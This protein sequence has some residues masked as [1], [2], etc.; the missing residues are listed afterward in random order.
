[1]PT[2]PP[3][4]P[5]WLM[6]ETKQSV[7]SC[8]NELKRYSTFG[9]ELLAVYAAVKHF[10]PSIEGREFIVYT[11][12]KPLVRA[13]ENGSQ[14]LTDREIRQLDFVTSFQLQMRHISDCMPTLSA[15]EIAQAQSVDPELEWVKNHTSL[16]LVSEPVQNCA[17][18]IWKDTSMAE[19]RIYIPATL[20]L[21]LF[22][23][24]HGLSHP[25][26]RATKRLFVTR[27]VWPG[28]QRDVAAWTRRC[29]HCQRT[30]I[31]RH[32]RSPPKEIPLPSSRFEHVHLDIVGPLPPCEGFRYLLTAM[33]RFTRW[34]EAWPIRDMT[35]Q[36]VAETFLSNWIA[37]FGV[38]LRITTDRGRQFESQVWL[39][40]SRFLGTHHIPTSAYH[41]QANGLVERFHRQLKAALIARMQAVRVKW[42][43][44]LPLVLLGIRTALKAD[45]GLAP[46]EMVYG[47]TLRLP[48]DFLSPRAPSAPDDPTC[49]TS[50]LKAAMRKLRPTP[51]RRN[52]TTVFVSQAL[53]DCTHVFIREPGFS[54]ALTPPYSGPH[55]V[56]RRSDK[57]IT[58]DHDGTQL[59]NQRLAITLPKQLGS[60]WVRLLSLGSVVSLT[61]DMGQEQSSNSANTSDSS[62]RFWPR[63]GRDSARSGPKSCSNYVVV[64]NPGNRNDQVDVPELAKLKV[65]FN[66]LIVAS[67]RRLQ[68]IPIFYPILRSNLNIPGLANPPDIRTKLS[69]FAMYAILQ[70]L[71][72]RLWINAERISS[73]Q[74]KLSAETKK[75]DSVIA[76]LKAYPHERCNQLLHLKGELLRID[77]LYLQ[78]SNISEMLREAASLAKSL[79][80]RFP[81]SD[82]LPELVF[83]DDLSGLSQ[84]VEEQ[85][86]V[87]LGV[88]Q[89]FS[90]LTT[91]IPR[92]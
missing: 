1:M 60:P 70:K 21:A 3:C 83:N 26:V 80:S 35:A 81:K 87:D 22:H 19:P 84:P 68:E 56:L 50:T 12:H 61:L 77:S 24:I 8:N 90:K 7:R 74:R 11:D 43:M 92:M 25:G 20:R 78:I 40:L 69:P 28:I 6:P 58:V 46:A 75:I 44:A 66:L 15:N 89:D 18:P 71:Q 49:F 47:S 32:T 86:V 55:A 64:V 52:S 76:G 79:N 63:R 59:T 53:N 91:M 54:G 4:S 82:R 57:T 29:L 33:D 73:E 45:L 31:H 37:R 41:P 36:T 72:N 9:R 16:R 51:P 38:P 5:S 34:P 13:F 10:R 65:T 30:K 39:T 85:R 23:A 14:G 67:I 17:Y 48:A 88:L 42:T 2:R 27:Y 62:F